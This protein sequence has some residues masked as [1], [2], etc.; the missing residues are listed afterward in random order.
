MRNNHTR[1]RSE[2]ASNLS[3][4]PAST[5]SQPARPPCLI[6]SA[7]NTSQWPSGGVSASTSMRRSVTKPWRVNIGASSSGGSP[8]VSRKALRGDWMAWLAE[9]ELA[10]A[11]LTAVCET[12]TEEAAAGRVDDEDDRSFGVEIN[13]RGGLCLPSGA[14]DVAVVPRRDWASAWRRDHLD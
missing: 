12:D 4:S 6:I 3:S 9:S 10:E 1:L 5:T 11:A 7:F 13:G 14:L 2:R 8:R